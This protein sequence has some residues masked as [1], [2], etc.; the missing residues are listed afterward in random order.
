MNYKPIAA[1]NGV[2]SILNSVSEAVTDTNTN[3]EYS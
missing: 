2:E 3:L 1:A